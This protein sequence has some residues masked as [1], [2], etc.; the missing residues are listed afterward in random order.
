MKHNVE[1][2]LLITVE[3]PVKIGDLELN[4]ISNIT[5]SKENIDMDISI[6]YDDIK[7]NGKEIVGFKEFKEFK[8]AM[9]RIG[10]NYE[11]LI[12]E[13]LTKMNLEKELNKIALKYKNKSKTF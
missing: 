10:I 8:D 4:N 5:I 13:Q 3:T 2:C 7:F 12:N 11:E 9:S 1:C 6:D